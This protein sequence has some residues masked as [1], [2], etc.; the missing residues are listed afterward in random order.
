MLDRK[1]F[2]QRLGTLGGATVLAPLMDHG[3]QAEI[4]EAAALL[5]AGNPLEMAQEE[6]LWKTI[7]KAY[8]FPTA[9]INLENGFYSP[10]PKVVMEA[11]VADE[12]RINH[13]SSHY[14]RREQDSDREEIRMRLATFAGVDKE[15][16]ALTRNTTESL[17][18]LFAGLGLRR[19]D[20]V[21]CTRLD[22]GSMLEMLAQME[23]R[24]GIVVRKIDLPVV[25]GSVEDLIAPFRAAITESTRL[26]L[27]THL[28]NLNGQILPAR[29]LCR[30]GRQHGIAVVVDAAHSF[31]HLDFKVSDLECDF[32]GSSL[33]KWLC[34][35]LGN[36]LLMVAKDK[37]AGVWPLLGDRSRARDD[38]RKFEHQGTRPPADWLGI[39]HAITFHESIGSVQK[40]ARLRYLKNY[41]AERVQDM[42]HIEL[43]TS[44][45]PEF[46]CAIA[47][48]G[49]R[50]KSPGEL[51]D[52]L[53]QAHKVFTVAIG[54]EGMQG[55]RVTPHVYTSMEE[56]EALV[57]GLEAAR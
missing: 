23:E 41:W 8:D 30:L 6:D 46:S 27:V 17:D 14:M 39:A 7:R 5:R 44:L 36:G 40:E 53:L 22:Y 56:V 32:L 10:M 12:R 15:T 47:N 57:R 37:I 13:V 2:L 9:F 33:H 45:L 55:V 42:P 31:A 1:S 3:L 48:V 54:T 21:I 50:G 20:E 19:G 11:H 43:H 38:I 16:V 24:D 4:Q 35:P 25:P 29:E 28:I 49:V 51:A 52:Y 34:A 26:M 18:L